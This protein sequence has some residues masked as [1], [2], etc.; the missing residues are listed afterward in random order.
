M[1]RQVI[2]PE[3]WQRFTSGERII[4]FNVD[5]QFAVARELVKLGIPFAAG[6]YLGGG[7]FNDPGR[8]FNGDDIVRRK[9][10]ADTA[11]LGW[12]VL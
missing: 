3:R 5:S 12:A 2:I 7:N 11:L 6:M 1:G 4:N 9:V 8:N 10:A